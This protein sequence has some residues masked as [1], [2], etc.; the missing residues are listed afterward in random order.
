[1]PICSRFDGPAYFEIKPNCSLNIS[2]EPQSDAA[3]FNCWVYNF[4]RMFQDSS[5]VTE[6]ADGFKPKD[7]LHTVAGLFL[8]TLQSM[9]KETVYA[10]LL[11]RSS[12][13]LVGY[14]QKVDAVSHIQEYYAP[15][16]K[17]ANVL[18][19]HS[20]IL[21]FS[22]KVD[23]DGESQNVCSQDNDFRLVYPS[24]FSDSS[25][26]S[27]EEENENASSP[28]HI[29]QSQNSSASERSDDSGVTTKLM[30]GYKAFIGGCL[31]R[32]LHILSLMNSKDSRGIGKDMLIANLASEHLIAA[33]CNLRVRYPTRHQRIIHITLLAV[34]RFMRRKKLGTMVMNILMKTEVVGPYDA[35]VVHADIDAK[36]FFEKF[37]FTDDILI[38]RAWADFAGEYT[39]CRLMTYLPGFSRHK[40]HMQPCISGIFTDSYLSWLNEFD[41]SMQQWKT[42]AESAHRSQFTFYSRIREEMKFLQTALRTQSEHIYRLYEELLQAYT[43]LL[44]LN[45]PEVTS[46]DT[47]GTNQYFAGISK[48]M[49]E[50]KKLKENCNISFPPE[51]K[52]FLSLTED[53]AA[54]VAKGNT[55]KPNFHCGDNQEIVKPN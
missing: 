53:S 51:D 17:Q 38:N 19:T 52:T 47:E 5:E 37:G 9:D 4:Y 3:K 42:D 49:K 25:E 46:Q 21:A 23:A 45:N 14:L 35:I 29:L 2:D 20:E 22:D 1:M 16:S 18:M 54:G 41:G 7:V 55:K 15:E 8:A 24:E 11:H 28:D 44:S 27:F 6:M 48:R 31:G 33:A 36:G 39:N 50:L 40:L 30:E 12:F 13:T 32:K 10:A 26:D 43:Q 34:R